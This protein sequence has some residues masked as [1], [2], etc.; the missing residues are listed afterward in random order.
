MRGRKYGEYER[1]CA[2]IKKDNAMLL[3]DFKRWLA[4]KR[5]AKKTIQRHV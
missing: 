5:L 1:A 4:D 3:A 2:E